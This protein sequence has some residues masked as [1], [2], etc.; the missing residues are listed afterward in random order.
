VIIEDICEISP[1][2]DYNYEFNTEYVDLTPEEYVGRAFFFKMRIERYRYHRPEE[3]VSYKYGLY[4]FYNNVNLISE[5]FFR[6]ELPLTHIKWKNDGSGVAAGGTIGYKF[7][8]P[9]AYI[10]GVK[11]I[12]VWDSYVNRDLRGLNYVFT[13]DNFTENNYDKIPSEVKKYM[14]ERYKVRLHRLNYDVGYEMQLYGI[15]GRGVSRSIFDNGNNYERDILKRCFKSES[16]LWH[17][18]V[19]GKGKLNILFYPSTGD[20]FS[21]VINTSQ[22]YY[23]EHNNS[24]FDREPFEGNDIDYFEPDLYIFSDFAL[25]AD[26]SED[27]LPN[28]IKQIASNYNIT[29]NEI[30]EIEPTYKYQY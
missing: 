29:I 5:L 12:F 13:N 9:A 6:H 26:I 11:F 30:C 7:I 15:E 2:E 24:M 25:L 27:Y 4:F 16:S 8:I 22:E 21:P 18:F 28:E 23:N 20:D 3:S 17:N 1:T 19:N 14:P 10:L